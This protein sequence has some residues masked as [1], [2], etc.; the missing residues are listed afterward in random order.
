MPAFFA[1]RPSS[2]LASSTSLRIRVETSAIALCTSSPMEGSWG[3]VARLDVAL[4]ATSGS[5][6]VGGTNTMIVPDTA[7][8]RAPRSVKAPC[9]APPRACEGRGAGGP[10]SV[11]GRGGGELLLD[12][13]HDRGVGERGDVAQLAV[14]GDV[15]QQPPHDL[16]G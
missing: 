1:E 9:R 6:S 14:L 15:A 5:S 16:A 12:Q 2:L 3:P 7:S 8:R 11:L 4:W 13:L 10:F